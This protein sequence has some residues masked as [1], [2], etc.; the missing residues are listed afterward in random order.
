VGASY[1]DERVG[2]QLVAGPGVAP[3][4][5]YLVGELRQR[6]VSLSLQADL[7][8]SPRLIV[9]LYAQPFATVGRYDRY[10]VLA[11]PRAARAADRFT[12]LTA[13]QLMTDD[14]NLTIRGEPDWTVARPDGAQRTVVASAVVR[15]EVRPG[16]YLTAV[17][18]HH[19]EH[20]EPTATR[21]PWREL[22]RAIREPGADVVLLKL[23]W[24]WAPWG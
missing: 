19:A 10:A 16:S 21:R 13:D 3:A 8:L 20:T 4:E 9:Q 24:R 11:D 22:G 5:T 23:G 15:W 17:W 14:T 6:T 12:A 2:W 1:A 7:A 18:S